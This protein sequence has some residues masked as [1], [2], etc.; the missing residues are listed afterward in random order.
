MSVFIYH[1]CSKCCIILENKTIS[2]ILSI[3]IFKLHSTNNTIYSVKGV[4]VTIWVNYCILHLY[5]QHCFA[6]FYIVD[7]IVYRV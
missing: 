7:C 4:F 5:D 3:L 6:S 1:V 2:S